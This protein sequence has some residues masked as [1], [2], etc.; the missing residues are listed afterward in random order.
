MGVL[1]RDAIPN[2]ALFNLRDAAGYTQEELAEQLTVMAR[3]HG[4]SLACTAQSISRWERGVVERPDAATRRLMAEFFNVSIAELGFTRPRRAVVSAGV[5][6][7]EDVLDL[8]GLSPTADATHA[9]VEPRVVQSQAEWRET[10]RALNARRVDLAGIATRLYQPAV[11]LR[12]PELQETGLLVRPEWMP[13]RPVDLTGIALELS[14]GEPATLAGTE[15]QAAVSLPLS[16]ISTR[17]PRYSHALRELAPPR[18]FENRLSYRLLKVDWNAP[19]GQMTFGHTSYFE[20]VDTAELLAHET[21]LGHGAGGPDHEL[22]RPSWRR[23]PFRKLVGDPF[24][25]SRRSVLPSINTLTIR[26][27]KSGSHSMILHRRDSASVAVAGGMLHVMPAGV[28]QPSSVLPAAQ[29]ADFDLWRNVMREY[30]E[31]FL[32][33]P[34]HDGGGGPIAYEQTE[35]FVTL[36]QARRSGR[37]RIMCLGLAL[38]ALSLVCEVLTVAVIDEDV[39]DDVFDRLVEAN[40]EGTVAAKTVPFEEHTVRR[41]LSGDDRFALAPAA[42]GCM[43]LAWEHRDVVLA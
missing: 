34:E 4:I 2:V 32:G 35:P 33:N 39:Y 15:P 25:L 40:A 12:G 16:T 14:P 28:F 24:D 1:A 23:L 10:R 27:S 31:E 18:L 21:A 5:T 38:D 26:R 6:T 41:L 43:M 11:R 29:E 3:E 9:V 17:Y 42:A 22:N 8:S 30:S 20:M 36:D 7:D 37:L 19:G 13:R